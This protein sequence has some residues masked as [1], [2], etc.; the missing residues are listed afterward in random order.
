MYYPIID[1]VIFSLGPLAV[2]WY[3]LSYIA[4][5]AMVWW[6]GKRRLTKIPGWSETHLSDLI[7]YGAVGVV[8][9][10]R[11]GYVF[12]YGIDRFLDDFFYLFR[13]WEG[14]M[15]FHGGLLGVVT[16]VIVFSIRF[17][18]KFLEV[19]DFLAPLC[20]LGLGFGR[21]ANFINAELPGRVTEG[22]AGLI[23]PCAVVRDLNPMCV[24]QWEAVA[25]HPSPLYQSLGEGL[26]LFLV[27]WVLS[28]RPSHT[29]FISGCFLLGYGLLRFMTEFFREP[30]S[31][32][33]FVMLDA[34]TMGQLL[35]LPMILAGGTLLFLSRTDRLG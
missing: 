4:G 26:V 1:P 17:E 16:A 31:H 32:M 12:F 35:C 10:G 18:K 34:L 22:F 6:L 11:F 30:D 9:G 14:G 28:S 29:G 15:S 21:L 5:F 33:G 19:G 20:P 24:G 7:F 25:R 27:L 8:V 23:Y 3:G 13:V 2:R